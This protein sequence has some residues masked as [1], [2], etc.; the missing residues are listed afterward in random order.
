MITLI[1]IWF[2]CGVFTQLYGYFRFKKSNGW[3]NALLII[4]GGFISLMIL[5]NDFNRD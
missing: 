3:K 1:T 4:L 5:L 2:I